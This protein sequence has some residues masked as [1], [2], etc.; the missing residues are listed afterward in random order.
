MIPIYSSESVNYS[1]ENAI[2]LIFSASDDVI[3]TAQP[4]G[5]SSSATFIVDLSKLSNR[6]DI[7]ADDNG[8]WKNCG[9]RSTYCSVTFDSAGHVLRV[10]KIGKPSV[11]RNSPIPGQ[12]FLVGFE[13]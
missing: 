4:I 8:V 7:R 12:P 5:C 9:V 3:C 10:K 13:Q 11:M 6:D 2:S 1:A